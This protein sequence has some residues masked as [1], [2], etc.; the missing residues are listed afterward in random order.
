ML[1]VSVKP[2]KQHLYTISFDDGQQGEIDKTVW[3]YSALVVGDNL[4]D[5]QWQTL[6]E[7]SLSH[8]AR[9]KALYYLSG[10]DYG[11]GE[12]VQKLFRA[13]IDRPLAQETVSRLCE[14]GLIDD[15]R[16]ASML[17]RDMQERKLYP[18]RRVAMALQEKGFSREVIA[19]A[20]EEL[21]DTEEEQALAMLR[22]KRYTACADAK[23][24]EKAL[25]MLARYGFSYTVSARAWSRL[26][27]EDEE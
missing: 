12:L 17:A 20:V 1:V 15:A 22:K 24:R 8:R 5:E 27:Q 2:A 4:S 21:D 23:Q 3:E 25:G 18:K 10:R 9:E 19:A 7:R 14:C 6:C 16:Y 13:G 26:E 11:S